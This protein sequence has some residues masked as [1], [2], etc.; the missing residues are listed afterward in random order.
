MSS[1]NVVYTGKVPIEVGGLTIGYADVVVRKGVSPHMQSG[2]VNADFLTAEA[3]FQGKK[4][5]ARS[6]RGGV[7]GVIQELVRQIVKKIK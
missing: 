5:E 3:T 7:D 4:Y 2:G 6:V 1:E